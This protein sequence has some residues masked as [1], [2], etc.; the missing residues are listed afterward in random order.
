MTVVTEPEHVTPYARIGAVSTELGVKAHV[1]RFWE[2][3][4]GIKPERSSKGQRVYSR[5][6]VDTLVEIK[7]LLREERYTIAGARQRLRSSDASK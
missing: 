3:E 4:F 6:Q 2:S 7:R 5:E 1:V